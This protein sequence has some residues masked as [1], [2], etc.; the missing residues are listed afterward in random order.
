MGSFLEGWPWAQVSRQTHVA[1]N[2]CSW[3]RRDK[4]ARR[5]EALGALA[6]L[7]FPASVG[8]RGLTAG[9][10]AITAT[11]GPWIPCSGTRDLNVLGWDHDWSSITLHSGSR[12]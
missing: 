11:A 5:S 7:V 12:V 1:V 4:S 9:T 6:E 10:A 2:L 8:H 3:F